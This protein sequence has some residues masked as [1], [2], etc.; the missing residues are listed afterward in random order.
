MS[1]FSWCRRLPCSWTIVVQT[2]RLHHNEA[3]SG[4]TPA[5]QEADG[6]SALPGG[7]LEAMPL[8]TSSKKKVTIGIFRMNKRFQST[9]DRDFL[10]GAKARNSKVFRLRPRLFGIGLRLRLQMKMELFQT[11]TL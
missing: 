10:I 6:T 8:G 9:S 4:G 2:P 3:E 5:I 1:W 11:R 7:T